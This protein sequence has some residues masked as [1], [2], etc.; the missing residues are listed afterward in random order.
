VHPRDAAIYNPKTAA[1]AS[2]GG[3][4]NIRGMSVLEDVRDGTESCE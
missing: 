3:A 4:K 2:I 1:I